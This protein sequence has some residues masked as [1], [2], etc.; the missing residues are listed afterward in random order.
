EPENAPGIAHLLARMVGRGTQARP[1]ERMTADLRAIGAL[2]G[3]EA[4]PEGTAY[5][6]VFGPDKLKRALAVQA[7]MLKNPALPASEIAREASQLIEE[8]SD[9]D[10][11]GLAIRRAGRLAYGDS[12]F[13]RAFSVGETA[14]QITRD[15][16]V[17]Y[18]RT[19][20]RP[21]N[22]IIV[23]AGD[24]A[25]FNTLVEIQ[26]LYGDFAKPVQPPAQAQKSQA[27]K[28][29][30]QKT[31]TAQAPPASKPPAS[32]PQVPLQ[33]ADKPSPQTGAQTP[34]AQT[35]GAQA[36]V[37]PQTPRLRY[38][39]ERGDTSQS[40]VT[41]GFRSPGPISKERAAVEVLAAVAGQGRASRLYRS[42]VAGQAVANHITA[43]YLSVSDEG[44][45]V[46]QARTAASLIDKAEAE[47]FKEI[48]RL[49][50]ELLSEA[51]IARARAILEKKYVDE[52]STNTG[53]AMWLARAE[54]AR[55]GFRAALDYRKTISQVS[56]EDVQR[57]AARLFDLAN[58]TVHEYEPLNA[59]AR[60]FDA[61]RFAATVLVWA[62]EFGRPVEA[63]EV[64]PPEPQSDLPIV[65]QGTERS[66]EQQAMLESVQPL[67]VKDFST[68][69]GPRAF[70]REDHSQPTV[71]VAILFQGGRI[72]EDDSNGGITEL[73]LRT[74]LH[75]TPRR[76]SAQ[77]MQEL[78]QL[79]AS[80][81][82]VSE[83][84][85]FGLI[86]SA[87]SRNADR[88]LKIMHDIIEE[89]AF[90]DEDIERA[91]SVQIGLIRQAR[92]LRA[93]RARELFFEALYP[94]HPY[95]IPLHG[96]EEA[97]A[98]VTGDQL[99][100]W[101][102]RAVKR[103]LPLA[104]IVGDTEGSAL[105]SGQLAE[106]FRRRDVEQTLK[107]R[108]PQPAP[109][110]QRAEPGRE[111][112]TSICVGF[113]GP[114]ADSSTPLAF[115]LI[116]AAMNGPTGRL[117]AELL[118]KQNVASRV[119][120]ESEALLTAGA[121]Y[122][123]VSTA[124]ENEQK[125]RAA[126]LSEME[127]LAREGLSGEEIEGARSLLATMKLA[128]LQSQTDHALEYARAV[129]YGREAGSVDTYGERLSKLTAD[130]IK[131]I[132]AAHFKPASASTGIVRGSTASRGSGQ[133]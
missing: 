7:D 102:A 68:L 35:T 1:A 123:S 50:R 79:G 105:V 66:A 116:E 41:L 113:A 128:S 78:E 58:T 44:L 5:R 125:A 25:T 45:L 108:I 69:N 30:A 73:M 37:E 104:V 9:L 65:G 8:M 38:A 92:D 99:R 121:I 93:V 28:S 29:Q 54:A 36:P 82:V 81:E 61:E 51:E 100:E 71:A 34:E 11:M 70:V 20:Y 17:E 53:R 85:F 94:T 101:H 60:T 27:Q 98:K 72:T 91:R 19:A 86:V 119:R 95:A 96:R 10:A 89:P 24:V 126:V 118:N 88:A 13:G 74:M 59:P 3:V 49:R 62:P 130:E 131:R 16:L 2:S 90:R 129:I 57:A 32:K 132:A 76:P 31:Q 39:A 15:Q 4:S 55:G 63:K 77:V 46:M 42:L 133:E 23:V 21:E 84:D 83:P 122:A 40:V 33:A 107:L 6:L 12:R 64:R 110:S 111:R 52:T 48:N 97:V 109:A 87:L 112:R 115:E 18:Y 80:I 114:K 75:G 56:A 67:P 14:G 43:D 124:P 103:H 120:L 106:G 22:L 26:Q 127:R 47:L 117:M